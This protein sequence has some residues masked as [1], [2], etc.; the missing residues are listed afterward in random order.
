MAMM[1]EEGWRLTGAAV[2]ALV[3][4]RCCRKEGVFQL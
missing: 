2:L 4:G 1:K 3:L